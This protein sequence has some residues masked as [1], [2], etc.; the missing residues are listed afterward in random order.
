MDEGVS[1]LAYGE[2]WHFFEQ[3]L[4]YPITSFRL[5]NLD[6]VFI[7]D[8]DQLIMPSGT[9]Y[10][11]GEEGKSKLRDFVRSGGK[12]IVMGAA[13]SNFADLENGQ[14][15]A[16]KQEEKNESLALYENAERKRLSSS[17]FGA[18]YDVN[19]DT[20]HPLAF[21]LENQ[22]F[23]LKTSGN[24]YEYLPNGW[25]VGVVKSDKAHIAG[26]AG[27]KAKK[28][29]ENSMV[30]GVEPYGRGEIIYLQDDPLFRAFWHQGKMLFSNAL[31]MVG[32]D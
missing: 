4:D 14:L 6:R 11:L 1:S 7:S 26:F 17:I 25:N 8:Y 13:I 31:F 30:F 23:S 2:I 12:L 10:N 9:Y 29:Q 27:Y 32:N 24:A 20:S 5:S 15:K 21:G 19:L 18:I 22:Y 16:K 28:L 3:S